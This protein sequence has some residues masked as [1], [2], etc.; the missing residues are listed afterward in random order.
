MAMG[1]PG[2][3]ARTKLDGPTE[4]EEGIGCREGEEQNGGRPQ[5][6]EHFIGFKCGQIEDALSH[7][8]T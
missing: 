7:F 6:S 8:Q 3:R 5:T 1:R 4:G 2:K